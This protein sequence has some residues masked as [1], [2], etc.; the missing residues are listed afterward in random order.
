MFAKISRAL[1]LTAALEM[2]TADNLR[3]LIDGVAVEQETRRAETARRATAT[4]EAQHEAAKEKVHRLVQ[5]AIFD[6]DGDGEEVERLIEALDERL[7]E[8]DAYV[9]IEDRPLREVVEQIC[10][11]LQLEVD[12]SR[13]TGEGWTPRPHPARPKWSEF[14]MPSRRKI[15]PGLPPDP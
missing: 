12:W 8:D 15:N 6:E 5:Q 14:N 2:K 7:E 4:V 9:N 1:R 3:A 11:D 10:A 13:W